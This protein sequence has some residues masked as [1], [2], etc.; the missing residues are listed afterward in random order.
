MPKD[1]KMTIVEVAKKIQIEQERRF[2]VL[3]GKVGIISTKLG[4]D[5]SKTQQK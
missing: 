2:S 1:K 4:I 5:W 3:E